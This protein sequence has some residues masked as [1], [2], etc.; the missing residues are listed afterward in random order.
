MAYPAVPRLRAVS[1]V[2]WDIESIIDEAEPAQTAV[3][4]CVKGN[5]KAEYERLE[6][7][8]D[9]VGRTVTNLA[10]TGPGSEIAERM[11]ELREQMQAYQ[12]AFVFR[13]VT[14]RRKWR[15]LLAKRPVKTPDMAD[16]A[17]LDVYHPWVCAVVAASALDPAM[18]P[19]Q[20]ERLADKLSDGDWQKLA[21]GAWRV[22]DD[23][24]EIPFS[25]AASVL[26]RSTGGKSRQPEPS[27]N[28]GH[29]SLAGS[30]DAS[31]STSTT[32]TTD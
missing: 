30:P 4:I 2:T 8:L 23:S 11:V 24:S 5:L 12:R 18:K 22:N 29:G 19:E 28:P 13:A 3:T 27:D 7:Q 31:P 6:T 17:F 1:G 32:S 10:G 26:S 21:Q 14:P 20:V 25:V 16:E 15:D 9:D